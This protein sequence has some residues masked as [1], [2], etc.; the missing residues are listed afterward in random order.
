M[1][2]LGTFRPGHCRNLAEQESVVQPAERSRPTGRLA[3]DQQGTLESE[4]A[5]PG[6]SRPGQRQN[7]AE[8]DPVDRPA[9][10][11]LLPSG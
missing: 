8:Q 5:K 1:M 3:T 10:K 4:K 9:Q 11:P 2:G 6:T 7:L